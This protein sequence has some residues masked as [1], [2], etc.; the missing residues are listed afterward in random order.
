VLAPSTLNFG[1]QAIGTTSAVQTL[2]LTN[3]VNAISVALAVSTSSITGNDFAVA[4]NGCQQPVPP[5][6]SCTFSLTFTPSAAG[7]RSALF[8][9]FDN[10]VTPS[11]SVTLTGSGQ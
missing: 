11:Q 3:P 7:P 9:V 8:A 2:T 1:T 6:G 5:G 10:A 4:Q